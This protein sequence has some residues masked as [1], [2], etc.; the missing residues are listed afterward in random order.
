MT[1]T[2][3]G[4]LAGIPSDEATVRK[5]DRT[6]VF[7]SWSAQALIDPLPIASAPRARASPTT[8]AS[9]TSTSPASWSTSTSATST[10]SWSGRSPTTRQQM[11]TIQPSFANDARS[12]GGPADHRGGRPRPQPGVLHQRRRRGQ[13]ERHPAGPPP[14]RSAQ[15]PR[16]V[17]QL[18]RRHTRRDRP[19]RRPA[20]LGHRA[21]HHPGDRA[22]LGPLPLP[23]GVPLRRRR[24]RRPTRAL[25]HLRDT[26]MVEG[27][28][29][30]RRDHPRDRSSV[31]TA[32]WSRRPA[33]WPAYARSATSTASC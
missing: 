4:P 17:P 25:Q 7:H 12:R 23:V 18:P 19:D 28:A 27:A 21:A 13:R 29:T 16:D 31:P 2:Y 30:D 8:T 22:L 32:S 3:D 1:P 6:H 9:P 15:G 11:T 5:L 33:T 14:H 10:P 26:I 24:R 20:S